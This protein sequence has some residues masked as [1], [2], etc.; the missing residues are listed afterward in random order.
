MNLWKF[1][2]V[3]DERP[4]EDYGELYQKIQS[5]LKDRSENQIKWITGVAG[6]L[7][8]VAYADMEISTDEVEKISQLLLREDGLE[9]DDAGMIVG[10]LRE[11]RVQLLTLE[12]HIY[13][14]LINA[15]ASK[16]QKKTLLKALFAVAAADEHIAPEEDGVIRNV[17][18][19]LFLSHAEFIEA[20]SAYR[21][22]LS[23][24]K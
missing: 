3:K 20:R 11:N 13:I 15:V 19:G 6:L 23:F 21:E 17:A 5:L 7:G 12:D 16:D 1:L 4:A 10:M 22:Y 8:K 9:A 18:K 2:G 24:L 14:R